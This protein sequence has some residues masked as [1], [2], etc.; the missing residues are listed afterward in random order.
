[1]PELCRFY[2]IVIQ[3]YYRDHPPPHFHAVYGGQKATIDIETLAFIDGG[4]PARARGLV[5]EWA[6]LHQADL[7]EAFRRAAAME[8]P[9]KID[10]LQ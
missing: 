8:A 4:L 10:P 5:V 6:A 9:G 3:M 2:G 1:M 7:R